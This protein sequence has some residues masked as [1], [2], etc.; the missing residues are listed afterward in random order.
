MEFIYVL[1][2]WIKNY[3]IMNK[4]VI[5][6]KSV[7]LLLFGESGGDRSERFGAWIILLFFIWV[8]I[9]VILGRIVEII[10]KVKIVINGEDVIGFFYCWSDET[11]GKV[12]F[13]FPVLEVGVINIMNILFLDKCLHLI[14]NIVIIF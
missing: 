14:A 11:V 7:G 12:T 3:V 6:K 9:W 10:V 8:M 2:K 5:D 1:R 13:I 4:R